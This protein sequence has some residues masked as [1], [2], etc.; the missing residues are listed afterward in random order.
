MRHFTAG[1]IEAPVVRGLPERPE[2]QYPIPYHRPGQP[3]KTSVANGA[4]LA[5]A[6]GLSQPLTMTAAL[7]LGVL[8]DPFQ[9][10][11]RL[12]NWDQILLV[13]GLPGRRSRACACRPRS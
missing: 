9:G 11:Y 1:G 13:G 3:A 6:Y 10:N 4:R 7:E 8:D 12:V 5:E 2:R